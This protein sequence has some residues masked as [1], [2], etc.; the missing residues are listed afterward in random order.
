MESGDKFLNLILRR[1]MG[2]CSEELLISPYGEL[3]TFLHMEV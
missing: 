2:M 1:K 3:W